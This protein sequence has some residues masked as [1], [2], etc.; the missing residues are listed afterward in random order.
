[1][2]DHR[3]EARTEG[4]KSKKPTKQSKKKSKYLRLKLG[5]KRQFDYDGLFF[6]S[7][8]RLSMWEKHLDKGKKKKQEKKL[9]IAY[10]IFS[11]RLI[12]ICYC[13]FFKTKRSRGRA[14]G[15]GRFGCA[16]IGAKYVR[17][18]DMCSVINQLK[19]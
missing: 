16:W 5:S 3:S 4:K 15:K 6:H 7:D 18:Q 1:M 19:M 17:Y 11:E 8:S 14:W 12:T 10:K 2:K 13:F 9:S